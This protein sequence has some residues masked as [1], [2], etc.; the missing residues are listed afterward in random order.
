MAKKSELSVQ[1]RLDIVMMILRKEEPISVLSRRFKVSENTLHRWKDDFL[2]GGK[3][4]LS[5]GR[6][7]SKTDPRG[8]DTIFLLSDGA[9]TEA[10]GVALLR[11]PALEEAVRAF[12]DANRAYGCV[13]HTIGIGPEHSRS[14]MQRL[15]RET[16]GTYKAVEH[17][18]K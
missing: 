9:P 8:A 12:L 4:A 2:E 15:A 5:Y 6:S 3:S 16:G 13:V 14:L 7:K 1:Q 17:G 11:G 18:T 10:G